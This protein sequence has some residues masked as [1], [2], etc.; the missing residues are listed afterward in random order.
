MGLVVTVVAMY[1]FQGRFTEHKQRECVLALTRDRSVVRVFIYGAASQSHP[2][3]E[4]QHHLATKM[5]P[6]ER[7]L[8]HAPHGV[9]CS[10]TLY[11]MLQIVLI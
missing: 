3:H 8:V 4:Y 6:L 7:K 11:R 1:L 5:K 9:V 10:Q 2:T